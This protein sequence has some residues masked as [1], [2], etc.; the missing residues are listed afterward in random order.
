MACLSDGTSISQR[1]LSQT[2]ILELCLGTMSLNPL[3]QGGTFK[4]TSHARD[5]RCLL[6]REEKNKTSV[7]I[8]S[9]PSK[10]SLGD[11]AHLRKLGWPAWLL[12]LLDAE[13][14][15]C[16]GVGDMDASLFCDCAAS[17]ASPGDMSISMVVV[18]VVGARLDSIVCGPAVPLR[19]GRAGEGARL[20]SRSV[21]QRGVRQ[22]E[23]PYVRLV[24]T[25][26]SGPLK[27]ARV[28][29]VPHLAYQ[30]FQIRNWGAGTRG[31]QRSEAKAKAKQGK[32][33]VN[34]AP[35]RTIVWEAS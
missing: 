30:N 17:P 22:V 8:C 24:H 10:P 3:A 11:A 18:V 15:P 33:L 9:R 2:I 23:G 16:G 19:R 31:F 20:K 35:G 29:C 32:A 4:L 34:P 13:G 14:G 6:C 7:Q 25:Q 1:E 28:S 12:M 27:G 5:A 26:W 21:L